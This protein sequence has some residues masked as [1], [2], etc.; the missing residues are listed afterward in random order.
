MY[1]KA[2]KRSQEAKKILDDEIKSLTSDAER[3]LRL[4]KYEDAKENYQKIKSK[5]DPENPKYEFA[6]KKIIAIEN[7]LRQKKKK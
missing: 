3:N 4:S 1:D 6:R 5:I 2:Y 7:L